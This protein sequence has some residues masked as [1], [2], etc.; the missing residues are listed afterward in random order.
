VFDWDANLRGV[1]L[2]HFGGCSSRIEYGTSFVK[3]LDVIKYKL[4]SVSFLKSARFSI[5]SLLMLL[6]R[7]LRLPSLVNHKPNNPTQY[8]HSCTGDR[9]VP[10]TFL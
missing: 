8:L 10:R 9:K 2:G 6:Q 7:L 1:A 4:F 3:Y 5:P